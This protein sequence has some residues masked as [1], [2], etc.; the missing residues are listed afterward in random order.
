VRAEI[1]A[2][3]DADDRVVVIAR[4]V[5]A[6]DASGVP[7]ALRGGQ[8]YSFRDGVI[9]AVDNYYE[10]SEALEAAGFTGRRIKASGKPSTP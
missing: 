4:A 5:G 3:L 2:I 8:I 6:G 9:T 10:P 7:V 1:E